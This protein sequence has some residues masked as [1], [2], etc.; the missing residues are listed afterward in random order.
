MEKKKRKKLIF[1]QVLESRM[2]ATTICHRAN[3]TSW[4]KEVLKLEIPLLEALQFKLV[5]GHPHM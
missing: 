2:D 3:K 1:S 4:D 5:V